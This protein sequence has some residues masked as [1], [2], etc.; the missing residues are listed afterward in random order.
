SL[1]GATSVTGSNTFTVG[2]GLASF[3]GALTVT[4][5]TS[6]SNASASGNIELT[7]SSSKLGI[8]AGNFIDTAL[9]VG[10]TASIS[11]TLTLGGIITSTNTGSNSFQGSI[12]SNLGIHAGGNLTTQAQFISSGTASNSFS[13]SLELTKGLRFSNLTQTGAGINYFAGNVGIGTTTPSSFKL[14]MAGNIGPDAD[15]TRDLG[16]ASRK[17]NN[18]YVNHLNFSTASVSGNFDPSANNQYDLGDPTYKWRTGYFGTSVLAPTFANYGAAVTFG[19]LS[20]ATTITGSGLTISPTAWTATPT[21]SGLITATSGLT[22][23]GAVTIQNNSAFS[24]TGNGTFGTG[25]GAVS[26]N[27]A[28]SVTGSNTFTVGTGLASFG[29]ALTVTGQTSLSNASASGNIE[30]TNS[31]SKLG[32]NGG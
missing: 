11:G 19:D 2:T 4:G 17:W 21:I 9:E 8:N 30:L 25:T 13:G 5:Q 12:N 14:E 3:G 23:N 7:N 32:I 6:L 1:N 31:S 10:G 29:G 28:T 20:Y 22:S 27:G 16:S 15:G 26:L 18:L 24:Q